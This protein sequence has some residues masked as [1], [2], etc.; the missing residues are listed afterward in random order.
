MTDAREQINMVGV[1]YLLELSV[2]SAQQ[3]VHSRRLNIQVTTNRTRK[4]YAKAQFSALHSSSALRFSFGSSS[5]RGVE[6]RDGYGL[7]SRHFDRRAGA[8]RDGYL[9]DAESRPVQ[10]A[11]R[12]D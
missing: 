8:R 2:I 1:F 12:Q 11:T 6:S 10:C 5:S 9:A 4:S 3:S 7:R